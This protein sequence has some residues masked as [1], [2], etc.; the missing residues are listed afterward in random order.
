M[1][2][3]SHL[4]FATVLIVPSFAFAAVTDFKSLMQLFADMLGSVINVVYVF[5]FAAF[6]WGIATFI[7]NTGD[8]TKMKEGRMWMLWSVIA[9][10]V[11]VTV[12]GLVGLLVN[13]FGVGTTVIPQLPT[14]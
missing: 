4:I 3:I 12:W 13:T 2:K 7:L 10:F 11:M 1:K 8:A 6:F 14:S 9:L 5:T